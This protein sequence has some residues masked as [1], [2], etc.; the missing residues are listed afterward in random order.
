MN[1]KLTQGPIFSVIVVAHDR[2][3]YLLGAL[4]SISQQTLPKEFFEVIIVKNFVDRES[5][6]YAKANSFELVLTDAVPVGAKMSIGIQKSK[7]KYIVFLEDDDLFVKSKLSIIYE[8]IKEDD[9]GFIH[10]SFELINERGKPLLSK[11]NEVD[12]L[13]HRDNS[14]LNVCKDARLKSND[15]VLSSC[16]CILKSIITHNLDRLS[17]IRAA[18]DLFILISFLASSY[19]GIHLKA[20]LTKY[21]LH[22]SLSNRVGDEAEFMKKNLEIRKSWILDYEIMMRTF[23]SGEAREFAEFYFGYNSLFALVLQKKR[24]ISAKVNCII[25]LVKRLNFL[26]YYSSIM[27]I[28]LGLLSFV[29]PG[30]SRK[31]YFWY[32]K[33]KYEPTFL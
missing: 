5:D 13:F 8:Q 12:V 30:I 17:Q 18:P 21:R 33:V 11:H 23:R 19:S 29:S 27:L 15:V 3:E 10:N 31:S 14:Y 1:T 6:D 16:M 9:C 25:Y 22:Q 26:F 28:I 20:K 32:R 2:R 7:G 24:G 4:K